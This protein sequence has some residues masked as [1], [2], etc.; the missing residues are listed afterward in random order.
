[1][2]KLPLTVLCSVVCSL[3]AYAGPEPIQGSG[4]E[5]KQA[6]VPTP[7]CD[8]TWTGF[9]I[10]GRAG[11][12]WD[13]GRF[14]ADPEPDVATFGLDAYR[15]DTNSDG[16]V[17]GGEI[18][19]NWQF[20]KWFMIGA[21]ADFSG[22]S[23]DEDGHIFPIAFNGT[24]VD[25]DI[26]Y[27]HSVD[28]F[29]TVRGRVGFVPTC[30]L[31]LYG[32]GGFAYAH[33][34]DSADLDAVFLRLPTTH[35]ASYDDTDTGYCAGG[36]L[37]YMLTRHW[38]IKAEYLY[39]NCGGHSRFGQEL[40]RGTPNPPFGEHYRWDTEFHTVTAGFNYKF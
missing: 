31:L 4:K 2:Q 3:V 30:R 24:T 7:E 9:Y 6:V 21:E 28:W 22:S 32:T 25:G 13:A 19:Y 26:H 37:E 12:G 35:H 16:F 38:S 34:D 20:G 36:G 11:Y 10:G 1:M 17:G 23:M 18:G 29:G 39:I 15:R 27:S 33:S 14:R 8:Y 40:V 5:M